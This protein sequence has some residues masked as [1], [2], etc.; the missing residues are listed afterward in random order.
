VPAFGVES[1]TYP[2]ARVG[3]AMN[4]SV[5]WRVAY[6]D[7]YGNRVNRV[8]VLRKPCILLEMD[9]MRAMPSITAK[10]NPGGKLVSPA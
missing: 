6:P 2:S 8:S 5:A 4:D 9:G 7:E 10:Y 1:G 3:L